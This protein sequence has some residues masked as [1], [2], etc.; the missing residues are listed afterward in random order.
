VKTALALSCEARGLALSRSPILTTV[1]RDFGRQ[2]VRLG[3]R[4]GCLLK[5]GRPGK[6]VLRTGRWLLS[7]TFLAP[8][9]LQWG[10]AHGPRNFQGVQDPAPVVRARAVSLGRLGSERSTVPVLIDHLAD[11]DPVVRLAAHAELRSRTGRDFGY[12]SWAS[13]EERA[14]AINRWRVWLAEANK[15]RVGPSRS[16]TL[17]SKVLPA[18]SSQSPV[19]VTGR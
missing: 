13:P 9:L 8:L 1:R 2:V 12:V 10:C 18:G 19:A 14:S 6:V 3:A 7:I 17:P 11:S 16:P 15:P 5:T 4:I